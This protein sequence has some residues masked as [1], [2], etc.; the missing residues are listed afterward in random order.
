MLDA[1][2]PDT[3]VSPHRARAGQG[4]DLLVTGAAF[5]RFWQRD[6]G[7]SVDLMDLAPQ[8]HER[9]FRALGYARQTVPRAKPER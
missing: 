9:A 7:G 2:T 5:R 6:D 8:P 1:A 3:T 4:A